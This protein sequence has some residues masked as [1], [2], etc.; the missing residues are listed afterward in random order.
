MEPHFI[1]HIKS[2]GVLFWRIFIKVKSPPIGPPR[3]CALSRRNSLPIWLTSSTLLADWKAAPFPGA[4]PRP[5][6]E[7]P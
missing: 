1:R 5:L 4:L 2:S 3:I 6:C 7:A